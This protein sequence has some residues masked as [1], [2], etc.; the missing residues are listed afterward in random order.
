MPC[1]LNEVAE[2]AL[3]TSF[4]GLH[5]HTFRTHE[6]HKKTLMNKHYVK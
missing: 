1:F 5:S 6:A 2:V 3:N 4:K